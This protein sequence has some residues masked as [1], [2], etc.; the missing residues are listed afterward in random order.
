MFFEELKIC[1]NADIGGFC[2]GQHGGEAES[3]CAAEGTHRSAGRRQV[4]LQVLGQTEIDRSAIRILFLAGY[5]LMIAVKCCVQ[6]LGAHMLY[7][8]SL[9][10]APLRVVHAMS[11]GYLCAACGLPLC[12]PWWCHL[13]AAVPP[14]PAAA[15]T[16][17]TILLFCA[18]L[19]ICCCT[20]LSHVLLRAA[21]TVR[22]GLLVITCTLVFTA[23]LCLPHTQSCCWHV[24]VSLSVVVV[25]T[26]SAAPY[27]YLALSVVVLVTASAACM[28]IGRRDAV[29]LEGRSALAAE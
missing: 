18:R 10:R 8:Y 27:V 24:C 15:L 22:S 19:S 20:V 23:P 3:L 21:D 28:C 13:D 1:L 6:L 25:V 7:Y 26:A 29:A 14:A 9:F 17:R 2:G 5:Q 11:V 4:R 16:L 12:C